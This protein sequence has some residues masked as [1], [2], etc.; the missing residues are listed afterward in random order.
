MKI[1]MT[2]EQIGAGETQTVAGSIEITVANDNI[3]IIGPGHTVVADLK[4]TVLDQNVVAAAHMNSVMP[5]FNQ[6]PIEMKI[7]TVV[8]IVRKVRRISNGIAL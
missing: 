4:K 3:S 7:L 2:H 1:T 8:H 5:A 6:N